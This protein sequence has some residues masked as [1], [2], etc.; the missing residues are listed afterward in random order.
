MAINFSEKNKNR[1]KILIIVFI[2]VVLVTAVILGKNYLEETE[3][4]SIQT[5]TI[6]HP[7]IKI[8]FEFLKSQELSELQPFEEIEAFEGE[9]G[10]DNPFI[11]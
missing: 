7:D 5:I 2:L 11:P 6:I 4:V 9:T 10:R 3:E 1:Q 8:N